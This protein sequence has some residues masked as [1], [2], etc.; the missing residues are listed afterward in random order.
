MG[1]ALFLLALLG[2]LKAV[3]KRDRRLTESPM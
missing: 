3:A 2:V 1:S